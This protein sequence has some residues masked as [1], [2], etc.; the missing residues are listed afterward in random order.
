[1]SIDVMLA[2]N[3]NLIS[4]NVQG[5]KSSENQIKLFE[6]FKSKLAPRVTWK[7]ELNKQVFLKVGNPVRVVFL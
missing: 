5:L 6:P 3:F 1:M 7:H 4:N 2:S